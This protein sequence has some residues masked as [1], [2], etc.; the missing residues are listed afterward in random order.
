VSA[1]IIVTAAMGA[2]DFAWADAL[3]RKHFPPERNLVPAHITLFHH[4]PPS[5]EAELGQR[6]AAL[7]AGR[8]PDARITEVMLLGGGVA[9]RIE[10][11][12]LLAMREELAHAFSSLLMPQDRAPPRLHLTIQNKVAPAVARA[13]AADLRETFRP[14]SLQIAGLKSWRYLDGPWEMIRET[15]FRG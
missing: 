12:E 4:L 2:A 1:P 8:P 15:R 10:S 7:C 3:R 5:I 14:R 9:F 11:P 13:L 6:M